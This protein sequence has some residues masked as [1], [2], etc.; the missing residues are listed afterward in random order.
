M[1]DAVLLPAE[2]V[3]PKAATATARMAANP[4]VVAG[5]ILVG[6]VI[7]IALLAPLL[8]PHDPYAQDLTRRLVPPIWHEKGVWANP[9]G[10]TILV[11]ITFRGSSTAPVFTVDRLS[12]ML[13]W[14]DRYDARAHRRLLR[15]PGRPHISFIITARLAMPVVL[16]CWLSSP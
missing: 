8:A 3:S 2:T 4:S 1:S 13:I 16:V 6:A 7:A 11:A 14:S 12:V 9:L 15:R 5:L 10:T